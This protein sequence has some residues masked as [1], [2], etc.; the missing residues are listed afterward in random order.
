MFSH[1]QFLHVLAKLGY[2][3]EMHAFVCVMEVVLLLAVGFMI[4]T[5]HQMLFGRSKQE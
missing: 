2:F 5:P 4:C 3:Q 1:K